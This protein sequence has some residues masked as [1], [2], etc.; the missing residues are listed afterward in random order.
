M[1]VAPSSYV[2][3][4]DH[5]S[6]LGEGNTLAGM[7]FL[8]KVGPHGIKKI[9]AKHGITGRK[10]R[11]H[12]GPVTATRGIP[13]MAAGGE[14]VLSPQEVSEIGDGDANRGHAMLDEWV[15]KN[16]KKHVKTLQKLPG[17]AHD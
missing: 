7:D 3:P 6:S 1:D 16:R 13:I 9:M 8:K 5:V 17:P 11:K 15:V 10:K 4:A 2:L 14:V 12:G